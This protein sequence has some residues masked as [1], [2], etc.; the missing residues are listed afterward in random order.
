[1]FAVWWYRQE[2]PSETQKAFDQRALVT[3]T[4]TTFGT[5]TYNIQYLDPQQRNF[6]PQID[7]VLQR[8]NESLSTYL[9]NSEISRFNQEGLIKF[10]LP[11]FYPVL[12]ASYQVYQQTD[13]AF[14]PTVGPLIDAWGFGPEA[15]VYPDSSLVDSLLQ[16]V[17]FDSVFFDSESVCRLQEGIEL[18]F[19]A[20]AKGQGVDVV[21]DFVRKQGI[22]NLFVEIGGEIVASGLFIQEKPWVIG[23][24]DPTAELENRR[25]VVRVKLQDRGVATSGNYR[26]FYERDGKRYAHTLDPNSGY[27][28]E[29]S[30]LSATVFAETCMLA[31][32]YATAFMVMGT[33]PTKSFLQRH[34]ELDAILIYDDGKNALSTYYTDGIR[35][36]VLE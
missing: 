16:F 22:Q 9:P 13:G 17:S 14:D 31:D 34:P 18:S 6:K 33:E 36:A 15:P 32:A 19:S 29:H 5:V 26:N 11:F 4:G 8:F 7:S 20:I 1:M 21:A 2:F 30:L 28:V 12:E 24:E 10:K 25:P 23:I 3:L 35:S 27:P